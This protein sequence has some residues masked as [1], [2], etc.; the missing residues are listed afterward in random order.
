M[1]A[2]AAFKR[3]P[4]I[5][6]HKENLDASVTSRPSR[7]VRAKSA[8]LAVVIYEDLVLLEVSTK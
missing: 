6:T 5:D 7:C 8:Q 1:D 3:C 2:A 4:S